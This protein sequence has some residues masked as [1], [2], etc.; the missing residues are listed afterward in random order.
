[1]LFA[2]PNRGLAGLDVNREG[3][4]AEGEPPTT[5]TGAE[6][7]KRSSRKVESSTVEALDG[8]RSRSERSSNSSAIL[9]S[10]DK[11]M[12]TSEDVRMVLIKQIMSLEAEN[13]ALKR[14]VQGGEPEPEPQRTTD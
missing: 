6:V 9:D 2:P 11:S 8:V 13:A 4:P 5:T 7:G 14:I 10:L 3:L 12:A 1:M